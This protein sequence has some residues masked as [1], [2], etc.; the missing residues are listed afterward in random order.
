MLTVTSTLHSPMTSQV[1]LTPE[2]DKI[3]AEFEQY[4]LNGDGSVSYSELVTLLGA[5]YGDSVSNEALKVAAAD[6]I[7]SF[8]V[9]GDGAVTYAEILTVWGAVRTQ[10]MRAIFEQ[11]DLNGD[12]TIQS[13]EL[14]S[15][16]KVRC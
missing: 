12:G 6:V 16:L 15:V 2:E 7:D 4:D 5:M 14:Y 9:D 8:D 1:W 11:Y 3:L 10:Q 13:T